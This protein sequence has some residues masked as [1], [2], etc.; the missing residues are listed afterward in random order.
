MCE[1][2]YDPQE[3]ISEPVPEVV[4]MAINFG[5]LMSSF[6]NDLLE[7]KVLLNLSLL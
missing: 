3:F 1:L 2:A 4:G 7:T 6:K 5:N